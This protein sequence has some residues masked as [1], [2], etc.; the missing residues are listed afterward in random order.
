MNYRG[1]YRKLLGNS[2]SA[3]V[4]AI[5]IYNKPR[6]EYRDECFVILLINGWELLLK[7]LLSKANQSIYYKK[8]R[9]EPYRTLS[10]SDALNRLDSRRI[11]PAGAPA[12]LAVRR[13]LEL[14]TVYRDNAVHYYNERNFG[15]LVYS[16]AQTSIVNYRDVLETGFGRSLGDEITWHLL[17]LGL[18]P[19]VD[20]LEYLRDAS[21]NPGSHQAVSDFLR[22]LSEATEELE[23]AEIDTGRLLTI[24]KVSLQS[25]KKISQADV[26]VGVGDGGDGAARETVVVRPLDPNRSHPLFQ[27]HIVE[28]IGNNLHDVKFT[29]YTFQAIAWQHQLKA[30]VTYCWVDEETQRPRWSRDVLVFLRGLT[31]EEIVTALAHYKTR[32]RS[33]AI[34]EAA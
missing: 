29:G 18:T 4:G 26:I 20:P 23:A 11:W 2:K 16:L 1:S 12:L 27:K 8:R 28:E 19:P 13:N 34:P 30:N 10:W 31:R 22:L 17:P 32:P 6:F 3:V 25:A 21:T 14:L 5:E 15:V 7:S 9:K 24:F 33:S